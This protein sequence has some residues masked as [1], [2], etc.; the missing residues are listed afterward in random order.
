MRIGIFSDI[1]LNKFSE[2]GG[3]DGRRRLEDGI[4]VLTQVFDIFRKQQC[5]VV[6]FCGDFFHT[7]RTIDVDTFNTSRTCLASL[8][9]GSFKKLYALTGNHD[10]YDNACST[11]SIEFLRDY[12]FEVFT[13]NTWR[14]VEDVGLYFVPWTPDELALEPPHKIGRVKHSLL[15]IHIIPYGATIGQHKF[16]NGKKL[17][18]YRDKFD[19][20]FCGDIHQRQYIGDNLVICGTPMHHNFGDTGIRG[21]HIYDSETEVVSFYPTDYPKFIA[22]DNVNEINDGDYFRLTVY[23]DIQIDKPNVSVITM[24]EQQARKRIDIDVSSSPRDAIIAYAKKY[25]K[26]NVHKLINIGLNALP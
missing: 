10:W 19:C 18:E 2:F 9:L 23:Q 16:R 26:G 13:R 6:V 20:I 21:V 24:K 4:R 5:D 3:P 8:P 1:H 11:S 15:F 22:T 12:G 25:G 17:D 7:R 14:K